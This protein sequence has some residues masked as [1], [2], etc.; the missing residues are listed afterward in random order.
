MP[1]TPDFATAWDA[2]HR[3]AEAG[4]KM[5]GAPAL[6]ARRTKA[7]SLSA[8]LVLYY[9]STAWNDG[10]SAASRKM[11][12]P[13]LEKL[14]ND[15][16][17]APLHELQRKHIQALFKRLKPNAQKNWMKALRGLMKFALSTDLVD[18]DPTQGVV[19]D[20]AERGTGFIAWT[21]DDL[22]KYRERWPLGTRQRLAVEVMVNLGLRRSDACRIGP[23]DIKGG[24]LTDFEPQKTKGTTGVKLTLPIHPELADV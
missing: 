20:K 19:K 18:V 12:R 7:G 14:R 16:G 5:L 22:A 6:G 9:A 13:I 1:G 21:E 11:R 23:N 17:D 3:V 8:A 10:L 15:Y 4:E 24:R 2:A